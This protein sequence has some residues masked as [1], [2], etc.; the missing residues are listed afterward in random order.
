LLRIVPPGVQFCCPA[1]H[2]KTDFD[3]LFYEEARTACAAQQFLIGNRISRQ[4]RIIGEIVAVV[5]APFDGINQHRFLQR[6]RQSKD[7]EEALSCYNGHLYTILLVISPVAS[8]S[9]WF[10]MELDQ[11][12]NAQTR[13]PQ[14]AL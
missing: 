11:Y 14:P 1:P 5:V 7:A 12:L 2:A 8:P 13:I 10:T 6:Y 9:Q 3:M 4:L